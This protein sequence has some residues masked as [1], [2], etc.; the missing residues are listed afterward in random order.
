MIPA[1]QLLD[2]SI[3]LPKSLQYILKP[4][5]SIKLKSKEKTG[6]SFLRLDDLLTFN[7]QVAIG[8]TLMDEDEFKKLLKKSVPVKF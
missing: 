2:I 1:I 8:D 4:K 5:A 6:K 3:L 7:W